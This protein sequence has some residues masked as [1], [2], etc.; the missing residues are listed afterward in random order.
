M[1]T[2]TVA[3]CC[4]SVDVSASLFCTEDGILVALE[5]IHKAARADPENIIANI[6]TAIKEMKILRVCIVRTSI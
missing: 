4:D 2:L 3:F 6:N 1:V 5:D